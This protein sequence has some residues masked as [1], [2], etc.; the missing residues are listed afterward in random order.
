MSSFHEIV[1]QGWGA[2]GHH[3]IY[4]ESIQVV[5]PV[6]SPE[7][8]FAKP[9]AESQSSDMKKLNKNWYIMEE[10]TDQEE[11]GGLISCAEYEARAGVQ[12]DLGNTEGLWRQADIETKISQHNVTPS[13]ESDSWVFSPDIY[14]CSRRSG[15]NIMVSFVTH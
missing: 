10:M 7:G 13:L 5:D 9:D 14:E 15:Q 1:K 2:Q 12:G 6:S 4:E 8:F 11:D 3:T